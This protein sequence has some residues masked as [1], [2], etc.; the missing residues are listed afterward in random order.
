MFSYLKYFSIWIAVRWIKFRV[1]DPVP[2]MTIGAVKPIAAGNLFVV[3]LGVH[4]PQAG[5]ARQPVDAIAL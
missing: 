2:E 3:S 1:R 4:L 5:T